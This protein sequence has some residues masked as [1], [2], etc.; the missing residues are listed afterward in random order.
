MPDVACRRCGEAKPALASPPF[1][2]DLGDQIHASICAAC[3]RA[4]L[5]EQTIQMNER[6]LS[7]ARPDHQEL[8]RKL[9]RGFLGL[10]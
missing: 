5:D 4:W 9:M 7:L 6:R 3:W 8:V 2:G 10:D 1:R